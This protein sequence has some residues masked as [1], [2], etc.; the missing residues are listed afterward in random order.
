M[1]HLLIIIFILSFTNPLFSQGGIPESGRK[2]DTFWRTFD[3]PENECHPCT[4]GM[5]KLLQPLLKLQQYQE[6]INTVNQTLTNYLNSQQANINRLVNMQDDM[7]GMAGQWNIGNLSGGFSSS[8]IDYIDNWINTEL[9]PYK[10]RFGED[11]EYLNTMMNSWISAMESLKNMLAENEAIDDKAN[12]IIRK[13]NSGHYGNLDSLNFDC[14]PETD[15]E[16][17]PNQLNGLDEL[18]NDLNEIFDEY[19]EYKSKMAEMAAHYTELL[20]NI[21]LKRAA[22][23][24]EMTENRDQYSDG[25]FAFLIG[26]MVDGM[27]TAFSQEISNEGLN[28]SSSQQQAVNAF[29][30]AAG[31]KIEELL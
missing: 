5:E 23:E 20:E 11:Y 4:N 1:K 19:F 25:L 6:R 16:F 15:Q 17:N 9:K 18:L 28:L 2:C 24:G 31:S 21:L 3:D 29:A 30:E 8:D 13:I 14:C 27:K 7:T 26:E 22:D 12:E 10:N